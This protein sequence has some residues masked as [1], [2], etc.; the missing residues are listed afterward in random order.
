MRDGYTEKLVERVR[1][2]N[3]EPTINPVTNDVTAYGPPTWTLYELQ[4]TVN[5]QTKKNEQNW[6]LIGAGN[7]T[8]GVIPLV[9]FKTGKRD[10]TSWKIEAPLKDIAYLQI[11]EFQQESNLKNIKE[12]TA[13]PMLAGNG[14]SGVNAKGEEVEIKVGPHAVLFAPPSI[15]GRAVGS[16]TY[17]EPSGSSLTFLK[18][19]LEGI[20]TEMRDLG[21]QPLTTSNLT[22]ITT[23]NVSMKVH[24]QVQAWA[25]GLKD[26]LEQ[27]W[28]LT[29]MWMTRDE[30]VVVRIHTDFGVDFESGS[31]LA[32][33]QSMRTSRDLSQLTFWEEF[34]RRGTLSDDFDPD[35]EKERLAEEQANDILT[36]EKHIDPK[37]GMPIV[38]TPQEGT[39]NPPPQPLPPA[40]KKK[41]GPAQSLQ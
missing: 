36:P 19:D 30:E 28:K 1:I 31:E 34:Q 5:E 33:L 23:A 32:A 4:T 8:I 25:L 29:C 26:A 38:V 40:T 18:A 11:E 21:M 14:V 27:A 37:T 6:V 39:L 17:I 24:N 2:L 22:V 15:D 13:F 9:P 16:W 41:S 7:I 10:G 20:R 35:M 12:L 3:R